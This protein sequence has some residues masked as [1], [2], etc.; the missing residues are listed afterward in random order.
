MFYKGDYPMTRAKYSRIE[1]MK[2]IF[3]GFLVLITA[4]AHSGAT[5]KESAGNAAD[6]KPTDLERIQTG[7]SAPDFTLESVEGE[8]VK[9]SSY[10][11][12]KNV[13]LVF[14]RGNW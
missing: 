5:S 3:L 14:Y 8:W 7:T 11:N 9:L 10:Q 1:I 6:L 13:I 2:T 4:C 12:K